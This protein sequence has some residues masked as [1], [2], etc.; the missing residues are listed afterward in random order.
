MV[1]EVLDRMASE[2]AAGTTNAS[3]GAITGML[4]RNVLRRNGVLKLFP[5]DKTCDFCCLQL[6]LIHGI[7]VNMTRET[8]R[9]LVLCQASGWLPFTH[10]L[11]HANVSTQLRQT[12]QRN[13]PGSPVDLRVSKEIRTLWARW[14]TVR[15]EAGSSAKSKGGT[16]TFEQKQQLAQLH[17]RHCTKPEDPKP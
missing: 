10:V 5:V 11:R 16:P 17:C 8:F 9:S 2:A 7:Y 14:R 4:V 1:V 6:A 12:P 13:L 15:Q 3:T